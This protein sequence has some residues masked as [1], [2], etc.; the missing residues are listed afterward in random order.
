M[1][2]SDRGP[3]P[4]LVGPRVRLRPWRAD[5]VDAVVAACQD[6]ETQRWTQVPVPY[7]REDAEGFVGPVAVSAWD[8]GGALFAVE[9]R[10]GG[11][12]LGSIGLF[13]PQDGFAEAGYWTAPGAR[14]RGFTAEA[15]RLLSTWAFDQLGLRR[16]ELH[17]DPDNTG[18]RAVAESAGFRAEGI[19]RQRFLHRGQPSDVVLYALLA[20][21]RRP[22]T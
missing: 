17:V 18:S 15:L 2:T 20:S 10:N 11:E 19:V 22:E 21:D 13:P 12:V 9:P 1:P 4:T 8:E 5:D 3:Q 16:V 14:R 7:H 6:P